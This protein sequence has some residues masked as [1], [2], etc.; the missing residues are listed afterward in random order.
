M[1]LTFH[2]FLYLFLQ[3]NIDNE[4][5]DGRLRVS[6]HMREDIRPQCPEEWK[7]SHGLDIYFLI[8]M[9]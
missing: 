7:I 9:R 5:H 4:K 3:I 8:G 6:F 2:L 1:F